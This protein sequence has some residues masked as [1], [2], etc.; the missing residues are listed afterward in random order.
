MSDREGKAITKAANA[1]DI[2]STPKRYFKNLNAIKE[3]LEKAQQRARD[4]LKRAKTP[5]DMKLLSGKIDAL[6]NQYRPK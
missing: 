5:G 1:L 4:A 3:N 2:T 6:L